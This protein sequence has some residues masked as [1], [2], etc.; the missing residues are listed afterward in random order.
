MIGSD[1]FNDVKIDYKPGQ[2]WVY[3]MTLKGLAISLPAGLPS[4]IS[5]PGSSGDTELGEMTW[6]VLSI[7]GSMV[8]MR[9]HLDLKV[10]PGSV[11][12]T[13]RTF[14]KDDRKALSRL[15]VESQNSGTEGTATWTAGAAE[16]VTVAAGNYSAQRINGVFDITSTSSN[17]A[18]TKLDQTAKLWFTSSI[19][20]V[21]EE[22]LTKI[23]GSGAA[24]DTTTVIELKSFT[25]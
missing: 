8:T 16:S 22:V 6:E 10:G 12:D 25:G 18:R 7:Q 9:T 5:F 13:T 15:Y 3:K 2:K 23:S 19:G 1:V 11:P 24:S 14:D 17:G 4:G 21:K 20:M